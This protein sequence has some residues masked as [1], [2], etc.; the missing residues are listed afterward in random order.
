M[1][2]GTLSRLTGT[3]CLLALPLS[4]AQAHPRVVAAVPAVGGRVSMSPSQLM[5]TFNEPLSLALSRLSLL[6]AEQ[7]AVKLDT[8]RSG[9]NDPKVLV[10]QI[11]VALKPG[12]YTVKWQASGADGH[13]MRGEYT[14]EVALDEAKTGRGA[15]LSSLRRS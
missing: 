5:L 9:M 13:P 7:Q 15:S 3:L 8:L 6:D 10:A 12:R 4:V 1:T 2:A 11:L 14:F